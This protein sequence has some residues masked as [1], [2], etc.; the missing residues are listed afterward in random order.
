METS[1]YEQS[2]EWWSREPL[3]NRDADIKEWAHLYGAKHILK[4]FPMKKKLQNFLT[5]HIPKWLRRILNI[6]VL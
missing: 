1:E 6:T 3:L 4:H 2:N 5:I